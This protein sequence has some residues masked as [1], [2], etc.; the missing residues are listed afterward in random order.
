MVDGGQE[1]REVGVAVMGLST[2]FCK[3]DGMACSQACKDILESTFT[4]RGTAEWTPC[5]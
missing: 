1:F 3:R 4:G 5:G 2:W